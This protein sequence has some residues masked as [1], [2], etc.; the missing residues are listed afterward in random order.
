MDKPTDSIKDESF[1]DSIATIT[2]E[3]KR[4]WIYAQKP[5]GKFYNAR[6]ILSIFYLAVFFSLPFIRVHGNPFFLFNVLERKF[7]F[8]GVIFWPQDFFIFGIGMLTFIL[9]VVLFTVVYGRVFCGWACPQTIFMEMVFRKIEYWIEGDANHQRTLNKAPYT[10]QKIIKKGFKHIVFFAIAF[11]IANTF[12]A[13]IIGTDELFEMMREPLAEHVGGFISLLV[14]TGAFYGVYAFFR[15]Q[16][17]LI[18]CPY[19]RL[20]GVML[21]KNSILVAYDYLRGEP[22]AKFKKNEE[23]TKGDCIDCHQCVNVCPTGIDI[24][25]GTQLECELHSLY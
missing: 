6:S 21:D 5:K 20:Q 23:R 2:K 18:V 14:F 24:R 7:I 3:G 4:N 10:S 25:H 13:Y 22:R 19:G 15:E 9:F 16:V 8:F 17:C 11:I 1:R 12:L